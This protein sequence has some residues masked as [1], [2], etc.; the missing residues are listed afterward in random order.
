MP[1]SVTTVNIAV[2][3]AILGQVSTTTYHHGNL[4]ASLVDAAVELARE[5]GPDGVALREV[6]RRVGV[7]HNAAYRHFADREALVAEVGEV[8]LAGLVGA[9]QVRLA[10]VHD[11]DP[12]RAA[13]LRLAALGRGYVDFGVA[14]PGLFRLV[15]TAYPE[16]PESD[17][18]ASPDIAAPDP[19]AMLGAA[20]D[21]LV[22][23]GY[24]PPERRPG[25]EVMCWSSVHGFA[26]LHAE[27]P[28]RGSDPDQREAALDHVLATID[29]S[30]GA[31]DASP[32]FPTP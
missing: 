12:V 16:L 22:V 18:A 17:P 4:R 23:V 15:F 27:G 1:R 9:M 24:L 28:L 13:R 20:L 10:E 26:V 29:R 14:E 21:E 30:Y 6:A 3:D 11:D 8:G 2:A 32:L 19:F 25:A 5:Q 31:P 7:S